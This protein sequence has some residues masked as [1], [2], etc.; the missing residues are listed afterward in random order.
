MARHAVGGG[1]SLSLVCLKRHFLSSCSHINMA[2][3]IDSP[4][5]CELP[6]VIRFLQADWNSTAEIR[7]RMSLAYGDSIMSYSVFRE[8]CRKFRD[9]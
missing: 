9:G 5:E 7:R 3:T 1:H 6:A 8:R 4:V 2:V